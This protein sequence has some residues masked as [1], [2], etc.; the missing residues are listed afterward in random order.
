MTSETSSRIRAFYERA[1]GFDLSEIVD[2]FLSNAPMDAAA[3]KLLLDELHR[4]LCIRAAVDGEASDGF[5]KIGMTGPVDDLWHVFLL[6]TPTY[7]AYCTQVAGFFIHHR[8]NPRSMTPAQTAARLLN[9]VNGYEQ[10]FGHAPP[11]ALWPDRKTILERYG[12]AHLDPDRF[13]GREPGSLTG[14]HIA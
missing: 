5:F 13:A 3:V 14:Q 12:F 7:A 1:T 4:F 10:A 11:A 8:P 2:A 6:Y 9:F